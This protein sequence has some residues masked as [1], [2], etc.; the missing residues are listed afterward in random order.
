MEAKESKAEWVLIA[1][2]FEVDSAALAKTRIAIIERIKSQHPEYYDTGVVAVEDAKTIALIHKQLKDE[3]QLRIDYPF[4]KVVDYPTYRAKNIYDQHEAGD[5]RAWAKMMDIINS[6]DRESL[7]QL[8]REISI[9]KVLESDG[10]KLNTLLADP[11]SMDMLTR[12]LND[13]LFEVNAILLA[14]RLKK[15]QGI[16]LLEQHLL[17]GNSCCPDQILRLLA[18]ENSTIGLEYIRGK[19]PFDKRAYPYLDVLGNYLDYRKPLEIRQEA[20]SIIIAYYDHLFGSNITKMKSDIGYGNARYNYNS[21]ISRAIENGDNRIV[22]FLNHYKVSSIIETGKLPYINFKLWRL[23]QT[24]SEEEFAEFLK[25]PDIMVKVFLEQIDQ[26]KFLERDDIY[27]IAFRGYLG[28]DDDAVMPRPFTQSNLAGITYFFKNVPQKTFEKKLSQALSV[29][30]GL[31]GEYYSNSSNE[32]YQKILELYKVANE[33]EEAILTYLKTVDFI[34][35]DEYKA[36]MDQRITEN[37]YSSYF[38]QNINNVLYR[39]NKS[40]FVSDYFSFGLEELDKTM[41]NPLKDF[42]MIR[43]Y[44]PHV[45]SDNSAG[46]VMKSVLILFNDKAYFIT[47]PKK[48]RRRYSH[49]PATKQIVGLINFILNDNDVSN[50]LIRTSGGSHFFGTQSVID[51]VEEKYELYFNR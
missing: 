22:P 31:I 37:P 30:E 15:K 12:A 17:S 34:S 7:N 4:A 25:N 49:I 40:F 46:R 9:S 39:T 48:E 44:G 45:Y 2:N 16:S 29:D 6:G 19:L 10:S 14:A 27:E 47:P 21:L 51:K 32:A 35:N 38:F 24:V 20:A 33:S 11:I 41:V 8:Y 43:H 5:P 13:S 42:E 3:K 23:E 18:M 36:Q 50:R 26:Q 1:S 28:F